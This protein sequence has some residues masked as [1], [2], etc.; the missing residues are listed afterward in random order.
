MAGREWECEGSNPCALRMS[1]WNADLVLRANRNV[2]IHQNNQSTRITNPY[3]APRRPCN[4]ADTTSVFRKSMCFIFV[5]RMLKIEKWDVHSSDSG[6]LN[7]A[8]PHV[9]PPTN[10]SND[11]SFLRGTSGR[12]LPSPRVEN[13][14][15]N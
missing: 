14:L 12:T 6:E 4:D 7:L 15:T 8:T 2:T 9:N 5:I 3:C 1:N 13:T 11:S 10:L